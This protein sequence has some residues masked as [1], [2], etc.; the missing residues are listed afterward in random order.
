MDFISV[1]VS[2]MVVATKACKGAS[3]EIFV[4]QIVYECGL[5]LKTLPHAYI[6]VKPLEMCL[7]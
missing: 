4:S 2:N 7:L 3:C 5:E 1:G 6:K